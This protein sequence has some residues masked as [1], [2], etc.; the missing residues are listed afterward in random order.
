VG[1][2]QRN[3]VDEQQRNA[4]LHALDTLDPALLPGTLFVAANVQSGF[5]DI[6]VMMSA[7]AKGH[8]LLRPQQQH[9]L[10]QQVMP[11]MLQQLLE[12]AA[13]SCD[14]SDMIVDLCSLPAAANLSGGAQLC[15]CSI[16][17]GC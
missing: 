7:L 2:Q 12:C 4:L 5:T 3:E 10:L 13:Q 6:P 1:E 15:Y 9:A 8:H 11:Q 16:H 14:N 17:A